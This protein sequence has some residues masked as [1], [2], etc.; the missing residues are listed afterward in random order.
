MIVARLLKHEMHMR[1]PVRVTVQLLQ[2]PPNR[3]IMRNRIRHRRNSSKPEHTLLIRAHHT[4]SI[5]LVSSRILHIIVARGIRLPDINLDILD[6]L[7]LHI[8]QRAHNQQRL[9][10]RIMR[11]GVSGRHLLGIVRVE[12]AEHCS[13]GGTCGLGVVD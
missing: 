7:P 10:L 4:P 5:R 1:R 12:R 2:Q 8:L 13:L 6:R 3:P 9:A 11:H